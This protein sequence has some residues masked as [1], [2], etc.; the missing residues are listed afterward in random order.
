LIIQIA[1][2]TLNK[3]GMKDWIQIK[4]KLKMV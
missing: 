2:M 4:R 1:R 3:K